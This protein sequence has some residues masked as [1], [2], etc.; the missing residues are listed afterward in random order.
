MLIEDRYFDSQQPRARYDWLDVNEG[1]YSVD[2]VGNR[3]TSFFRLLGG[4]SALGGTTV[5]SKVDRIHGVTL[6][7]A[8]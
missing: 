1:G 2:M 6:R 8:K 3:A 7:N 5:F 4:Q